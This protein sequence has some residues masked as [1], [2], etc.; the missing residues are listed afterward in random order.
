MRN[1]MFSVRVKT[2]TSC[3]KIEQ[4]KAVETKKSESLWTPLADIVRNHPQKQPFYC[5]RANLGIA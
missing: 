3:H 5:Q 4:E 2:H 1:L